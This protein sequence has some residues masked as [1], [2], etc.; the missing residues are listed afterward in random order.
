M[1]KGLDLKSE[2]RNTCGRTIRLSSSLE[3]KKEEGI[4]RCAVPLTAI[5]GAAASRKI[6]ISISGIVLLERLSLKSPKIE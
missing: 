5:R 1:K 3:M 4:L 6:E 2:A